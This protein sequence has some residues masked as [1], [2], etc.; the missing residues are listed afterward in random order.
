M[1]K[2]IGFAGMLGSFLAYYLEPF[3]GGFV[4]GVGITF[5]I[6][7]KEIEEGINSSKS[8][9]TKSRETKE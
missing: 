9:T 8:S 6:F 7:G 4:L 1:I 3:L 2:V 5:I